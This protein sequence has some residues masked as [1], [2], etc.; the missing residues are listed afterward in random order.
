M[1]SVADDLRESQRRRIAAMPVAERIDLAFRLGE[2]DLDLYCGLHHV[3]RDEARR[4]FSRG[5]R[6]GRR[7]SRAMERD[8]P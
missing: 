2:R 5:R 4:V 3:S 7:P 1:P 6:T 8:L